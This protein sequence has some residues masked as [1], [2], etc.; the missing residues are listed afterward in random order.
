LYNNTDVI[1]DISDVI[2]PTQSNDSKHDNAPASLTS[3]DKEISG[4]SF[5]PEGQEPASL[6]ISNINVSVSVLPV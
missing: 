2:D 4:Y 5:D 6:S 3:I 1:G